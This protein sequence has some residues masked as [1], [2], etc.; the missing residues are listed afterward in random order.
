MVGRLGFFMGLDFDAS[1]ISLLHGSY[2]GHPFFTRQVCSKVHQI[3]AGQRPKAIPKI[4]VQQA[5]TEFSAQL[6]S[7][8]YGIVSNLRDYYPQEFEVLR[9]VVIGASEEANEFAREAPDLIDHLVGYGLIVTKDETAELAF[10]A[11]RK[12]VLQVAPNE[13]LLSIEGKW[14][15]LCL[16]R[17]RIENELRS[18]LFYWS[19]NINE[20]KFENILGGS[21]TKKRLESLHSHD[22]RIIFSS[23]HSPLYLTD[24]ICFIEN[25]EVLPFLAG[26]RSKIRQSLHIINKFRADAHAKNIS[27]EDFDEARVSF[28][29]LEAVL[30]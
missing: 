12:A 23:E 13:S 24:L 15:E 29:F 20:S 30:F 18:N 28:E 16:R 14:A 27:N 4:R 9:Q 3:T 21:L 19:K 26:Y 7:Y 10:D 1:A 22:P 6:E 17:N 5:Q 25:E 11:V 8:L 2:G